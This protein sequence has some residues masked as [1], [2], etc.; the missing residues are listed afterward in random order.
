MT[1]L[2]QLNP[3]NAS[4]TSCFRTTAILS[5][6]ATT[7]NSSTMQFNES[8]WMTGTWTTQASPGCIHEPATNVTKACRNLVTDAWLKW[9]SLPLV[10]WTDLPG[11]N[12]LQM[13]QLTFQRKQSWACKL[14]PATLRHKKL[15][16]NHISFAAM[17]KACTVK[18]PCP[19]QSMCTDRLNM[20]FFFSNM[21]SGYAYVV[22]WVG[23]LE[24]WEI[25]VFEVFYFNIKVYN[26]MKKVN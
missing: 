16:C 19:I 9:H 5:W 14:P 1:P 10:H 25:S 22:V 11:V 24:V 8:N 18:E 20:I 6:F 7:S 17:N 4:S 3:I 15:R 13:T 26:F 12:W 21:Q 2:M 23:G